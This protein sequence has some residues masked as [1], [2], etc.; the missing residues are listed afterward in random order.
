MYIVFASRN[1]KCFPKKQKRSTRNRVSRLGVVR[2]RVTN[3]WPEFGKTL[4]IQTYH[5]II[6]RISM[7]LVFEEF[8]RKFITCSTD[9][10]AC[11]QLDK[12][13]AFR[14][15]RNLYID[16]ICAIST[17]IPR[18][19]SFRRMTSEGEARQTIKTS[20]LYSERCQLKQ[21]AQSLR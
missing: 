20:D 4:Q 18:K 5:F 7:F 21:H 12:T 17:T 15:S 1:E 14:F 3:Y 8:K 13:H 19:A 11:S 6:Y 16:I 9:K 2:T 10:L